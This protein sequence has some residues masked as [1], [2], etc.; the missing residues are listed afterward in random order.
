MQQYLHYLQYIL[1]NGVD[2]V[3]RTGT[4]VRSV[5]GYQMRFS[6]QQG[7]PLITTKKLHLRSIIHE[8]LWSANQKR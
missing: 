6:L 7:F 4:G 8:L 5:F 1:D 2:K 3:D